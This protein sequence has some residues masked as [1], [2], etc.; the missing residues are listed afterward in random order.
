MT[1]PDTVMDP[2]DTRPGIPDDDLHAWLDGRLPE[3]QRQTVDARL[4]LDRL[5][6]DTVAAYRSQREALHAL[7]RTLLDEPVPPALQAAAQRLADSRQRT[8]QWRRWGGMA[9]SVP[10]RLRAGLDAATRN[11]RPGTRVL[12]CRWRARSALPSRPPWL[13]PSISR[14]SA[15]R[16]RS[17]RR[18]RSIWC[19]GC[20]GAW[21]RPLTVPHAA[22]IRVLSWW[23][24]RLLPGRQW[25]AAR[26]SCTRTAL[27]SAS[28]CTWGRWTAQ[29]QGEAFRLLCRRGRYRAFYWLDQ[30]LW[31]RAQRRALAPG[32]A[33]AGHGRAPAALSG[34]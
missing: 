24:G 13:T 20:P 1:E 21:R 16:S 4:A 12:S 17:R 7:H 27:G 23:G 28:P 26:S 25:R 10:A 14:S 22:R 8:S 29:I 15:T 34:P 33:G 3:D 19:N 2:H 6:R 11:G 31:L 30:R 5:P 18:S 32:A 9:A